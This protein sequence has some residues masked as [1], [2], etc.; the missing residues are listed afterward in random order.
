MRSSLRSWCAGLLLTPLIGGVGSAGEL[1]NLTAGATVSTPHAA[2]RTA[3][4]SVKSIDGVAGRNLDAGWQP[5]SK[6]VNDGWPLLLALTWP[7]EVT[8]QEIVLR[9]PQGAEWSFT[10]YRFAVWEGESSRPSLGP[11]SP[12]EP[13]QNVFESG[14]S[15]YYMF[16]IPAL[17]VTKRGTVLAFSEGRKN[18]AR[19]FGAIDLV[20][21]RSE[22]T[23]FTWG[24][25]QV[26][27]SEPSEVTM[28]NVVPIADRM[29][30]DVHAVF[31]EDARRL[32]YTRSTD[33]G[34]TF[35]EPVDLTPVVEELCARAGM[36]WRRI[37]AGPGR[38]WQMRSGRLVVPIK[39]MGPE[40]NGVR[41][42][43]GVIYSDDHGNTWHGSDLVP[44]TI[45][46]ISEATVFETGDGTLV[47]NIRW[48]D[49][50]YRVV[51][52]SMDGGRTWSEALPDRAL[53]D[54]GC[55]GSILRY[56]DDPTD[57]RVIFSNLDEQRREFYARRR[58][59][60]RLST[61]DAETWSSKKLIIPG[62]SGYSDLAVL[63]SGEIL[64]I[65]ERGTEVY[66]EYLSLVR[67]WPEDIDELP[68]A[69]R[70]DLEAQE[71]LVVKSL[72]EQPA[73]KVIKSVSGN[74]EPEL[75]RHVL[76]TPLR[77]S[78]LFLLVEGSHQPD[79]S[80]NLQEIEV[81][82]RDSPL[83]NR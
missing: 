45:G 7:H 82:G 78:E 54:P 81:W 67:F 22:D 48:H 3:R 31:C 61:D 25:V 64:L 38:G 60:V 15:G 12:T 26:V 49:G 55:Q 20:V 42:R 24:P 18:S 21:K 16:R 33:E 58:L 10:D 70:P 1:T 44:A 80:V 17:V 35:A 73:W 29:T 72:I 39:P 83:T 19:D 14:E 77:T 46:E 76:A 68:G 43:V 47:M 32:W 40:Q 69:E 30:G 53:P 36:S 37:F 65:M 2:Q 5:A 9:W 6:R 41:R 50:S 8:I 51:S 56:S 34:A 4:T 74:V 27:H 23:G 71:H 13:I 28:G 52:R 59:T 63:P 11:P 79:G 75:R 62:P 57:R 66:S